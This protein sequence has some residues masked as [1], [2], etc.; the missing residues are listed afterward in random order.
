MVIIIFEIKLRYVLVK[1]PKCA[2][3]KVLDRKYKTSR[4]YK[5]KKTLKWRELVSY[6]E[7]NTIKEAQLGI[8]LFKGLHV[9]EY[10]SRLFSKED[11]D[12]KSRSNNTFIS[13]ELELKPKKNRNQIYDVQ[14]IE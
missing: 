1:C 5:C 4:C 10:A 14:D 3:P 12:E 2:I 13:A 9:Y 8:T 6:G 7:W 11:S